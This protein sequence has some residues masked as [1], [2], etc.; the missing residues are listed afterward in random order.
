MGAKGNKSLSEATMKKQMSQPRLIIKT[1]QK[2]NNTNDVT[3]VTVNNVI[4][5]NMDYEFSKINL[6]DDSGVKYKKK[7]E[8]KIFCDDINSEN[9]KATSCVLNNSIMNNVINNILDKNKNSMNSTT[10]KY[11]LKKNISTKSLSETRI[12]I[13][14]IKPKEVSKLPDIKEDIP[15]S[16]E[17][18]SIKEINKKEID[19]NL[20]ILIVND[21]EMLKSHA[22]LWELMLDLEN[23]TDTKP[24]LSLVSNKLLKRLEEEVL[25]NKLTFEL[26]SN[27][28]LNKFYKKIVKIVSIMIVFLKHITIDY[29]YENAMRNNVKKF[30]GSI[31]EHLLNF[32]ENYIFSRDDTKGQKFSKEFL[33]KHTSLLKHHKIKKITKDMAFKNLNNG[34]LDKNIETAVN[35]VK[36][37][38]SNFF[39]M[40]YFKPLHTICYEILKS[41]ETYSVTNILSLITNNILF[42]LIHAESAIREKLANASSSNKQTMLSSVFIGMGLGT[43]VQLPFLPKAD[44]DKYCLVLDLDETLVHFFFVIR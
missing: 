2:I 7:E 27:S 36:L 29:N 34:S 24:Y 9:Y 41:I 22:A 16:I 18:Q 8:G 6:K 35:S 40:G 20:E 43:N 26:F 17:G 39:K 33:E 23:S 30:I 21:D 14:N 44:P 28:N 12:S 37:F 13:K 3:N 32:V 5:N 38:S 15:G 1:K 31:N 19:N 11:Y 10:T 4:T 25:Q 42:Y